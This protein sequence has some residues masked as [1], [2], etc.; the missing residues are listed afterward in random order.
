L[1][2]LQELGEGNK[3]NDGG[4]EFNNDTLL[5]ILLNVMMYLQYNNNK[6]EINERNK[7]F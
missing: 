1:K 5:R 7:N 6:K 4:G 3:E 2:L